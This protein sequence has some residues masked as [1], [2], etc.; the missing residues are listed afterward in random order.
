[1]T[2]I[3]SRS[4]GFDRRNSTLSDSL[5]EARNSIRSSTDDLFLPRVQPGGITLAFFPL[6]LALLPAIAGIFFQNGSSIVTDV[7]LLVLA[8]IF[9]NWSVRLP[10]DWYRSAQ[11]TR[12]GFDDQTPFDDTNEATAARRELQ[13]H[14]LSALTACFIFPVI[15]TWLLHTIRG[16][17]SRPSEGLVSN[18]NLTIFLLASEVRPV[19]HLLRLIQ[20]RTLYLQRIVAAS[21]SSDPATLADLSKRLEELEAHV[22]E[23]AVRANDP[24]PTDAGS[25]IAQAAEVRKLIQPD[26]EALNRAVRRYEKRSALF[27]LQTDQ[28]FG[29]LEAQAGDALALAAAAQRKEAARSGF[30]LVLLEWVCACVVVPVQTVVS[31]LGLPGRV[32]SGSL[33]AVRGMLG[34][35]VSPKVR[36]KGKKTETG[37]ST[38]QGV[39]VQRKSVKST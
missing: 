11:A 2:D 36:A 38:R 29:R 35:K 13:T 28:R 7:T 33:N 4:T 27:A 5:S 34:W 17:L 26:I 8:A 25:C 6:G 12:S 30:A 21:P 18:Y 31:V 22:A 23:S 10:W 3:P 39:S 32:V 37:S 1:M 20:K 16:N 15:G 9:L 14:E 19:A 24:D